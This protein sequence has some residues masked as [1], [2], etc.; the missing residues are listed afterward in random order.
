MDQRK[1]S[2]ETI[3]IVKYSIQKTEKNEM[4][5]ANTPVNT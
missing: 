2:M 1:T 4:L 5:K 3:E